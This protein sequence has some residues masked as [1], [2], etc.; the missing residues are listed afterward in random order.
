MRHSALLLYLRLQLATVQTEMH[1]LHRKITAH[2]T[3]HDRPTEHHSLFKHELTMWDLLR[4]ENI[5]KYAASKTSLGLHNHQTARYI[6]ML[7]SESYHILLS[8][9]DRGRFYSCGG[10]EVIKFGSSIGKSKFSSRQFFFLLLFVV[11]TILVTGPLHC[12]TSRF[13]NFLDNWLTDGDEVVSLTRRPASLYPQ[14]DSWYSFLLEAETTPGPQCG[15]KDCCN[16]QKDKRG[17]YLNKI[18]GFYFCSLEAPG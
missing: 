5:V 18:C 15:W 11:G 16:N 3:H 4:T 7:S 17:K 12:K 8:T 6:V 14:E 2:N 13:A 1:Y 9:Q 10:S